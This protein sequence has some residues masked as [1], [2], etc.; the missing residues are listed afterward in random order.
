MFALQVDESTDITG[1]AQ[2]LVFILFIDDESIVK[3]FLVE[4][5]PSKGQFTLTEEEELASIS[6][7][8]TLK[9]KHFELSLDVYWLLVEKE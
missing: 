3:D 6:S 9:L 5:E 4:F 1:K 2:P 8:R 7:D